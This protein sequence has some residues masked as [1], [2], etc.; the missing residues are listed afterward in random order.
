[1]FVVG[2]NE[3]SESKMRQKI[4]VANK[5]ELSSLIFERKED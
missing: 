1:M 3:K 5:P 2:A 4:Y